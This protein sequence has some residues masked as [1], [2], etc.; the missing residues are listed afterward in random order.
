M[1]FSFIHDATE[2]MSIA[3]L[4]NMPAQRDLNRLL[5]DIRGHVADCRRGW[6]T[7]RRT[8]CLVNQWAV[9]RAGKAIDLLPARAAGAKRIAGATYD[10]SAQRLR[11]T[12]E[13]SMAIELSLAR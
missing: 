8:T 3:P 4:R 2:V 9:V 10:P 1:R 12:F 11:V 7:M 13:D 5:D 6:W